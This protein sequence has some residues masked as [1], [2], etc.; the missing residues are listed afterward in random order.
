MSVSGM[1][2]QPESRGFSSL[3]CLIFTVEASEVDALVV[4]FNFS[5]PFL[6]IST[7]I[8]PAMRRG[9]SA[10][11]ANILSVTNAG[12]DSQI[13]SSAVQAVA[14]NVVCFKA[15][16]PLQPQDQTVKIHRVSG[17]APIGRRCSAGVTFS[18]RPS[19][20]IHPFGVSGINDGVGSNAAISGAER[21]QGSILRLHRGNLPV[22]LPRTAPT[23]A[24][25]LGWLARV[26]NTTGT[27]IRT[28]RPHPRTIGVARGWFRSRASHCKL[29]TPDQ[30]ERCA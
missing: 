18:N 8:N 7:P 21:N 22:S 6:A 2:H 24:G 1:C 26:P 27:P 3:S 13:A 11:A 14:V 5:T 29:T 19:P 16:S 23:V 17:A 10:L 15:I 20:L 30:I 25:A 4:D 28:A 9:S 12:H